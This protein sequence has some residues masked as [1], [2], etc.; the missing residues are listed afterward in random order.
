MTVKNTAALIDVEA[1]TFALSDPSQLLLSLDDLA[2][3]RGDGIFETVLVTYR[4]DAT[5]IHNQALHFQRFI[6][7]QPAC[8][9]SPPQTPNCGKKRYTPRPNNTKN[10]TQ[11]PT[12]SQF[13]TP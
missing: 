8:L 12:P 4:D 7:S 11:T 10:S 3:H 6:E 9:N 5:Y 13:A 2:A 1:K